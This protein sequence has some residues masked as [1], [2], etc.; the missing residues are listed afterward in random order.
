MFAQTLIKVEDHFSK[1]RISDVLMTLYK[2]IWDDFCS[3]FLEM[4]KPSYGQPIDSGTLTA[5]KSLLEDNLKLLHPFMPFITEE[6]WHFIKTRKK[7]DSLI[8][9]SWPKEQEVDE[10]LIK[11]FDMA[12]KI[13][14]GIR[15]FRKEKNIGQKE[16]LILI[17]EGA[18]PYVE[19][20]QKLGQIQKIE[21]LAHGNNLTLGSFRVGQSEYFIPIS[22]KVDP[23]EERKKLKQELEYVKG[24][25]RS[26]EKKLSNELFVSN[27]PEKVIELERKK[28]G[29]AQQKIALLTKRLGHL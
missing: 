2:L 11:D 25:L 29:D 27:A 19:V 17:T 12:K 26:V 16:Q 24:F 22:K 20:I 1:Y 13:I 23:K 8:I 9:S 3:W 28:A 14:A 15:K 5:V 18:V 4:I 7:K 10:Q 6:L 21:R